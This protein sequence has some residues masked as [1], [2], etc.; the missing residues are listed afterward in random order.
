MKFL[1]T[2]EI[3]NNITEWTKIKY[4]IQNLKKKEFKQTRQNILWDYSLQDGFVAKYQ[5]IRNILKK[6]FNENKFIEIYQK[7]YENLNEYLCIKNLIK[8]LDKN[9]ILLYNFKYIHLLKIKS[10]LEVV[11]QQNYK[12]CKII[13]KRFLDKFERNNEIY[14]FI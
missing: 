2:T 11:L 7:T 6:N 1:D 13:V 14:N 10:Y 8:S 3:E 5:N 9:Q 12:E 4:D